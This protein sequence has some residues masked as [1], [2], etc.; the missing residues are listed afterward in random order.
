MELASELHVAVGP[1][2]TK[3]KSTL[4]SL[5]SGVRMKP[6]VPGV[7][8]DNFNHILLFSCAKQLLSEGS[9]STM[10]PAPLAFN[11]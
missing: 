9:Y 5:F 4:R 2:T 1:K 8:I 3:S 6:N 10:A 7:L 11:P